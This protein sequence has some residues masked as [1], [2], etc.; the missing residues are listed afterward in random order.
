MVFSSLVF[1][2]GFLPL[3]LVIYTLSGNTRVKNVVLLI[4]SLAFYAWGEP[5]YV[6]LLCAVCFVNY[7]AALKIGEGR[8][9]IGWLIFAWAF[10]IGVLAVFK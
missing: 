8:W 7:F 5:V 2:Y 1:L 3:N 9:E 10:S 4:M 6:L